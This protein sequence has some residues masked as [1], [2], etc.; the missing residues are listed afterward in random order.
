[1]E[2]DDRIAIIIYGITWFA[3]MSAIHLNISRY[4]LLMDQKNMSLYDSVSSA[5]PELLTLRGT[6]FVV[7]VSAIT[8][9]LVIMSIYCTVQLILRKKNRST[10]SK[11]PHKHQNQ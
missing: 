4:H 11:T 8:L 5:T 9:V 6:V 3:V 2:E 10:N 7:G 1:M